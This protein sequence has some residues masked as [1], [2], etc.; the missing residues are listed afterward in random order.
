MNS[1][2]VYNDIEDFVDGKQAHEAVPVDD[3]PE[4]VIFR[5]DGYPIVQ[6]LHAQN[7]GD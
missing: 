2:A 6:N 4:V 7:N 3:Q 5:I 1:K